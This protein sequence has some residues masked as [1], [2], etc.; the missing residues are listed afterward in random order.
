MSR[1]LTSYVTQVEVAEITMWGE[2]GK[3]NAVCGLVEA[4]LLQVRSLFK[5][6]PGKLYTEDEVCVC[7]GCEGCWGKG[8]ASICA[9]K[10]I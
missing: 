6:D 5:R 7:S 8:V 2:G 4:F 10:E 3:G 9:E 1:I